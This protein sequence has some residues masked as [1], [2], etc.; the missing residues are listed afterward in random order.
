M[1]ITHTR[2]AAAKQAY[3]KAS[4]MAVPVFCTPLASRLN[5][6]EDLGIILHDGGEA[7]ALA[8]QRR[9]CSGGDGC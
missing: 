7:S 9:S 4:A 1:I 5:L 3:K 2:I 6:R 8:L